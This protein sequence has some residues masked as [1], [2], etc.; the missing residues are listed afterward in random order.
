MSGSDPARVLGLAET[1]ARR[2]V[3]LSVVSGRQH[4]HVLGG[5]GSGKSTLLANLA[6]SDAAAGRGVVLIDPKGDLVDDV[7]AR[8]PEE[9]LS[10][11]VLIDPAETTAPP[12]LNVLDGADPE[13]AVDQV[14]GVFARIFSAWWGP[15]TDDV[16][17]SALSTLVRRPGASLADVPR[18]LTDAAWRAPLVGEL[19]G[20]GRADAAGLAGFWAHFD[21]LSAGGQ[22]QVIGPVMNKLRAVLGRRFARDL[23]GS[24]SSS[25]DLGAVLDGG[26]LLVRLPKGALGEDTARLVG[27]LVVARAWQAATARAGRWQR[28]D[29]VIYV[30]E[31]QN[32]MNLPGTLGDLLAEARGYHVGLVLAHQHLAQLPRDLAEAVSANARNKVYFNCSPEDA[33]VL[34]RHTEPAVPAAVL[35]RLGDHRVA[36]RLVRSGAELSAF[37]LAT[38]PLPPPIP[39]RAVA[40]RAAARANAGRPAEARRA[41]ELARR[42]RPRRDGDPGG[43][44]GVSVG[45]SG[46][47][48]D[49]PASRPNKPQPRGGP[50]PASVDPD[51][52]SIS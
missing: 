6:L 29:A 5:T 10:R 32:F 41:E 17:R 25:F 31:C 43:P 45:V 15:R 1:G 47:V 3:S 49:P 48:L 22:A 38:R 28:R 35:S 21:S 26:V 4:T 50:T 51:S 42:R 12:T 40:A 30:D 19:S 23:L 7:L 8:L 36:V 39:G 18:L 20:P 16:L 2:Q 11:L 46:G 33:R 34:A 24:G 13:V 52:W 37:T 44:G 14:T 27:S 9:S